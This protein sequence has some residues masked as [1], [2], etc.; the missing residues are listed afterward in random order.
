MV[1]GTLICYF[2]IPGCNSLKQK[3]S[4]IKPLI[5]RL[6]REFNVSVAEID[7]QDLKDEVVICCALV[8][9]QQ[10]FAEMNL[11]QVLRF[12][13][14]YWNNMQITKFKIEII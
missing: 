14:S 9:N 6:H 11:S 10:R 3:R 5:A 2:Y 12:I 7:K 1:I 4:Q 8:C 13:E